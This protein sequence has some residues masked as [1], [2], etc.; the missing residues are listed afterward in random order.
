MCREIEGFVDPAPQTYVGGGNCQAGNPGATSLLM[1][2]SR[3]WNDVYS[4]TLSLQWIDVTD[5]APGNYYLAALADPEDFIAELDEDNNGHV[6][7]DV[8][9]TVPGH[10]ATDIDVLVDITLMTEVD[11][12]L[13]VETYSATIDEDP[14]NASQDNVSYPKDPGARELT[15]V[16]LP[17][18]GTLTQGGGAVSVGTPFTDATLTY[19]PDGGYMGPDSFDYSA[20]DPDSPFPLNPAIATASISVSDNSPPDLI[21]P[22]SL[23]TAAGNATSIGISVSDPNGD[24]VMLSATGLPPGVSV[25]DPF[26]SGTPMIPGV[27]NVV[28][29]AEDGNGAASDESFEWT[30][31]GD[32]ITP[33]AD[34]SAAHLF[35]EDITWMYALGI[36]LG[37]GDGTNYC[38]DQLVSR[39]QIASFLARSFELSAG[40]GADLFTDDDG[41]VHEDNI[42]RLATAGVTNGCGAALFCPGD[43]LSRAQFASLLIR[44]LEDLTGADYSAAG[45]VDYFVD[46]DGL[47]HEPNIDKLRYADVT[48][49]CGVALFCPSQSLTRGQLAA[50]LH[51]ALG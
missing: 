35:A 7:G 26:L 29:T 51:R 5:L 41:L 12:E 2:T 36:S 38:P 46:D 31:T 6:F 43:D 22:G 24:D 47:T 17:A 37:C 39:G 9:A 40:A 34:V 4:F 32:L 45:G 25:N 49:G 44:A 42:D 48:Q 10:T 14:S 16:S 18:H 27:Y 21:N 20:A 3:G 19:T 23:S 33:F 28:V 15:V 30:V 50:L 1:G 11:A 8:F 13:G